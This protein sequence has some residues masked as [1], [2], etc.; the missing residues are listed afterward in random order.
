MAK[1]Y[2]RSDDAAPVVAPPAGAVG[3]VET[4]AI[5]NGDNNPIHLHSHRLAA[6]AHLKIQNVAND[7]LIYVWDGSV[8]VGANR[9]A[10][11]SSVTLECGASV[12]VGADQPA[13]VFIFESKRHTQTKK[14]GHIHVLPQDRVPSKHSVSDVEGFK[15]KKSVGSWLHANSRCPT[16]DVWLHENEFLPGEGTAVHSHTADEIIVVKSGSVKF[17]SRVYERGAAVAIAG[18]AK[19]GFTAGPEGLCFLNYRAGPSMYTDGKLVLDEAQLMT[20]MIGAPRYV[21]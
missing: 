2:F 4:R 6:G 13:T 20:E 16:C 19:Y 9:L 11:G 15:D 3:Q 5:F 8:T 17:G 21:G 10:Q 1:V 12:D 7:G 14:G 18:D